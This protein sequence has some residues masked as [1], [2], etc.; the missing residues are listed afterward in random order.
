MLQPRHAC[1]RIFCSLFQHMVGVA[2]IHGKLGQRPS[3][4]ILSPKESES[5]SGSM[6]A[7]YD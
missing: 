4:W 7:I 6:E 3:S 1:R 2:T 5:K